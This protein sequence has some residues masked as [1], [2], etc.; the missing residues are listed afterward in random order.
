ML[1]AIEKGQSILVLNGVCSV[2]GLAVLV[3]YLGRL[4]HQFCS[5]SPSSY[6]TLKETERERERER[7]GDFIN[8]SRELFIHG[9]AMVL[10]V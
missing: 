5:F 1:Y 2:V 10:Y 4:K 7:G 8:S 3:L 9:K 6:T